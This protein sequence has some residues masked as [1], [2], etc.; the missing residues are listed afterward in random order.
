MPTNIY[1]KEVEKVLNSAPASERSDDVVFLKKYVGTK[2][3]IIGLGVPYSRALFKKGYS[4]SGLSPEGQIKIW[5]S[6]WKDGNLHDSMTQAIFFW[7]KNINRIDIKLAWDCLKGWT[8]KIDNWA[9]SDGLSG[10]YSYL[11][12][13]RPA[14][15]LP[16]LKKWNKSKN[17]WERRQSV[18]SLL[19]YH[20]KRKEVLPYSTLISLVEN[21]L[22]DKDYFVQKGVG[23]ALR[24]IGNV[25]HKE[26]FLFLK[27]NCA[28]I[29]SIA[30]AAAAEK[31]SVK[32]KEELKKLRKAA[33]KKK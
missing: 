22:D 28:H 9:H 2:Y 4:F 31:L 32:E 15:V 21:L 20:S 26:T 23:W 3:N 11:L 33:R 6:I 1:L 7:E 25:Y 5:D 17:L 12:E 19:H 13:I 30:F 18:V 10:F 14:M 8:G 27:K 16:Q 29:S 24:E